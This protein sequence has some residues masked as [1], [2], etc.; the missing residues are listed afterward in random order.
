MFQAQDPMSEIHM[1]EWSEEEYLLGY[2]KYVSNTR[3]NDY[4]DLLGSSSDKDVYHE[5]PRMMGPQKYLG[6]SY[7]HRIECTAATFLAAFMLRRPL[8]SV[9]LA[10]TTHRETREGVWWDRHSSE[11]SNNQQV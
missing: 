7:Y 1:G 6:K 9:A 5:H 10:T 2:D 11:G 4:D 3:S 8:N